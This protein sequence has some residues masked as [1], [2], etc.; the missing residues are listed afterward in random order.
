MKQ[1]LLCLMLE[2]V[3]NANIVQLNNELICSHI[4]IN[5]NALFLTGLHKEKTAK[6]T[7]RFFQITGI[8][9]MD[10][11]KWEIVL[12]EQEKLLLQCYTI[13]ESGLALNYGDF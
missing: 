12:H 2:D 3:L 4:K 11:G 5:H 9:H 1:K 10:I 13:K 8:S 7:L 6:K